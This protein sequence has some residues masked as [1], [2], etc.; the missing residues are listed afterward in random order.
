MRKKVCVICQ[1]E[2]ALVLHELFT[3]NNEEEVM[4]E[5]FAPKEYNLKML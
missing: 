1:K 3:K 5:Q 2:T 4:R